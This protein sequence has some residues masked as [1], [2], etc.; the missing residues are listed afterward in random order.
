MVLDLNRI[1]EVYQK[2]IKSLT[3]CYER[4]I[5]QI[6]V[7]S[8]EKILRTKAEL[9]FAAKNN[10]DSEKNTLKALLEKSKKVIETK[11]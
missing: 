1:E 3:D 7:D 2:E 5:Q 6:E 10:N 9:D 11:E 4:R 8:K